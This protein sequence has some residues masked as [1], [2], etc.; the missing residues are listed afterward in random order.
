MQSTTI[1]MYAI[2]L[3][4]FGYYRMRQISKEEAKNT[5]I[6]WA[7]NIVKNFLV[8]LEKLNI[9]DFLEPFTLFESKIYKSGDYIFYQTDY[10]YALSIFT[11]TTER[12][13][14]FSLIPIEN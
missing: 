8:F 13:P 14:T 10:N 4:M 6:T 7:T 11:D 5:F 3:A 2:G 1:L 9:A 12:A